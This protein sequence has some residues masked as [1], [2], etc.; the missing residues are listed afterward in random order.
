MGQAGGQFPEARGLLATIVFAFLRHRLCNVAHYH[1]VSDDLSR[2]IAY[3]RNSRTKA[4]SGPF[5]SD[6]FVSGAARLAASGA[7][8]KFR[9]GSD[10]G[11]A[12]EDFSAGMPDDLLRRRPNHVGESAVGAHDARIERLHANAILNRVKQRLPGERRRVSACL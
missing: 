4:L 11:R 5:A 7:S 9:N 12:V 2:L 3:R 6:L 1:Q 8:A 10:L